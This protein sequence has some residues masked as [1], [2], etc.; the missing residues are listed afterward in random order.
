MRPSSPSIAADKAASRMALI[1]TELIQDL[2]ASKLGEYFENVGPEQVQLQAGE[3]VLH[4]V[5]LRRDFVDSLNLPFRLKSGRIGK[6]H[7]RLNAHRV[8]FTVRVLPLTFLE[9]MAPPSQQPTIACTHTI[10]E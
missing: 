6:F 1:A 8:L 2:I 4:D 5:E 9:A 3:I 7:L 10:A